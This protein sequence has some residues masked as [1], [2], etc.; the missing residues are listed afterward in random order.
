LSRGV[1]PSVGV[2]EC[3]S[4][5]SVRIP[6]G[7][8]MSVCCE[9]CVLSGRVLCD[10]LITCPEESY[11]VLVCLSV[12]VKFRFESRRGHGCLSVVSVVCCQVEVSATS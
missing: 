6:P 3:D 7:T 1:L 9:C 4:E 11:R 5:V 12:I 2:S 10:E 8:R